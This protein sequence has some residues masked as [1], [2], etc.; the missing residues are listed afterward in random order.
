M[1]RNMPELTAAAIE[2]EFL[3]LYTGKIAQFAEREDYE[4]IDG[5]CLVDDCLEFGP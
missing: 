1:M 4:V 5:V 3:P 2:K